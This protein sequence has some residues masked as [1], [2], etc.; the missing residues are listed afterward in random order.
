MS[1]IKISQLPAIT[2][3]NANTS[4]NILIGVDLQANVTGRITTTTLASGLYSNNILNVG[5]A[6][7]TFPNLIAQFAYS[8]NNYIQTNL[9]NI[10]NDNGTAD[11]VITANTGTDSNYYIDLGYAN[12]NY[13][14]LN[15]NFA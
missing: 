13:N 9:Q 5:S 11:H 6:P 14:N 8:S 1:T 12:K 15:R 4:N 3:L 2:S 10:N 7:L